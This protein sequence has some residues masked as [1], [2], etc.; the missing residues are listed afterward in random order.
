[1][2]VLTV[3]K[4]RPIALPLPLL[5]ALAMMF[6]SEGSYWRSVGSLN[7]MGTMGAARARIQGL[8]QSLL[9]ADAAEHGY[10]ATGN[11]WYRRA[12][13]QAIEDIGD[14][15]VFL[16][17]YYASQP[18]PRELLDRLHEGTRGTLE[19]LTSAIRQH[20]AGE[21]GAGRILTP[22]DTGVA[23]MDA[24]QVLGAELLAFEAHNVS[25]SRDDL[26]HALKLGRIGVAALSIV[27][28]V[29]L[30]M[31]LR[32]SQALELQRLEQQTLL[33]A[34]RGR[35][36][37]EVIHR[38][39]QLT[40]LANHLQTAREDERARLARDLH[41]ELGALL[42]SAKLDAARIRSRL[43][44]TAPEAQERLAHLVETLNGVIALKRRIL[45]DLRPSALSHL[46][47]VKTLEILAREFALRSGIDVHCD[48]SEVRLEAN[49][50]LV[51][52]RIVQEAI[53]NI[54]KHAKASHVWITLVEDEARV[55]ATVRD[56]GIGFDP[57]TRLRS[58][59]GLVGMQFRVEAEHGT[60]C[61]ASEPGQ[62][63]SVS[64][65]L[66]Q[67]AVLPA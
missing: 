53:T 14:A 7:D 37:R 51:V 32:Q 56:D 35:L 50:E 46:G 28:L 31:Y 33:R 4:R 67:T 27:S 64:V 66:P 38:T 55:V 12:H 15:F 40:Q 47:L 22:G 63:T 26:Y 9:D 34:E 16:D 17:H 29:A 61:L 24:V 45:E 43:S 18:R 2:D 30:F 23:R 8:R 1:M 36:E 42:T 52:Y 11:A 58:A 49:S 5:A 13:E 59:Y 60:L 19:E 57:E 3:V 21:A 39:A 6:I 44:G 65:S 20:D 48:L 25:G 54:A 41:D 62:G 10:R